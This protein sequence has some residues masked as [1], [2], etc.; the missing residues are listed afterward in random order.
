MIE[1]EV[2]DEVELEALG[3]V[4]LELPLTRG[5]LEYEVQ[6]SPVVM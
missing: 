4:A 2:V 3:R 1:F 6:G 5:L